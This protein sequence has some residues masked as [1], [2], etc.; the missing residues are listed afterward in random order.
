MDE[1]SLI[2]TIVDALGEVVTGKQVVL[3]PGDDAAI[4][5]PRQ[6]FETV[7]SID[8]L[9]AER[10]FPA[11]APRQDIGYR[12]MMVSL[13]DLAAMGA[14]PGYVLIALTLP[15]V[16]EPW[17]RSLALGIAEAADVTGVVVAGGNLSR[18]PLSITVSVHGEVPE[19]RGV[20]RQRAQIGDLVQ[21]SGELG[22]A[23][24]CVR[25]GAFENGPPDLR[26]RYYRPAAR[27]DVINTVRKAHACID[28]SDGLLQDL[29]HILRA[30]DCGASVS[31][32]AVPVHAD[33]ELDD[34]LWGGDDYELLAIAPDGLPG[35]HTIGQIE[36]APGLQLDGE[37]VPANKGYDH[38]RE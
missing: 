14:E 30:S 37:T 9:V 8:T 29:Q 12:A 7:A 27:F 25:L 35:F 11:G 31:S 38:F 15:D 23:A 36:A 28:I 13:S 18:G 24:A 32:Q 19:G 2:D 17:V 33:A 26:A 22:G 21:V 3:G 16:D 20:T 1:F 10:H 6:G 5:A 34:A 4:F